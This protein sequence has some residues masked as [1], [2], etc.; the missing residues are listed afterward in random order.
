MRLL[1]WSQD[2]SCS[3]PSCRWQVSS[4]MTPWPSKQVQPCSVMWG[5]SVWN[6]TNCHRSKL[7]VE[8]TPM[9]K[10]I[11]NFYY[12]LS[13]KTFRIESAH[14]LSIA[15]LFKITFITSTRRKQSSVS[16]TG[17]KSNKYC[18]VYLLAGVIALAGPQESEATPGGNVRVQYDPW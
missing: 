1:L 16:V 4:D 2:A 7:E 6:S 9:H 11:Y 5:T 10:K 14:P 18:K 17:I 3:P 15:T 13:N 12:Y 8:T